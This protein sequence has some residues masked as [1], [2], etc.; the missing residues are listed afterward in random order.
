M[1]AP[2]RVNVREHEPLP[3]ERGAVQSLKSSTDVTLTLPV[4]VPLAPVTLKLTVTD[5]PTTEGSGLSEVIV[6]VE[7]SLLTVMWLACH[8]LPL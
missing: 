7:F 4:G 6:V 3:P 1:F 5:W 2:A 8:Q